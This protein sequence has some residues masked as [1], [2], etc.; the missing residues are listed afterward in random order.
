MWAERILKQRT[1]GSFDELLGQSDRAITYN[2]GVQKFLFLADALI[3]DFVR[4]VDRLP[5]KRPIFATLYDSVQTILSVRGLGSSSPA[6]RI[7]QLP[8]ALSDLWHEV[9][10]YLFYLRYGHNF[11]DPSFDALAALVERSA[12]HYGD[13]I[14]YLYGF[15]RSGS[16]LLH[17]SLSAV[18]RL[19][20]C[21]RCIISASAL[22]DTLWRAYVLTEF[23]ELCNGQPDR[24]FKSVRDGA[25]E[26]IR[27][28]AESLR[29]EHT[30]L[31]I[32]M[33]VEAWVDLAERAASDEIDVIRDLAIDLVGSRCR[34]RFRQSLKRSKTAT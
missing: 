21:I 3:D 27:V 33:G 19:I 14:V 31:D 28:F 15:R 5:D 30:N 20:E 26:R 32:R 22:F 2:G 10:I 7:F 18:L 25:I 29:S 12:D 9:G 13:L 6:L 17:P 24:D 23:D 8:L 4:R 11:A 16:A 34:E 1:V